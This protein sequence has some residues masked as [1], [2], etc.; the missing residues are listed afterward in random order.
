MRLLLTLALLISISSCAHNKIRKVRVNSRKIVNIDKTNTTNDIPNEN[1]AIEV[2]EEETH[3]I[4]SVEV[5][6]DFESSTSNNKEENKRN[7]SSD[8]ISPQTQS[9]S[10]LNEEEVAIA[11]KAEKYAK[12]S[13]RSFTLS[14]VLLLLAFPLMVFTLLPGWAYYNASRRSRYNTADGL[15]MENTAKIMGIVL[16]IAFVLAAT[17]LI[18]FILLL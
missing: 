8:D 1:L 2:V 14:I 15:K 5:T 3:E 17:V 12:K 4:E 18:L 9:S 10:D 7:I 11:I 13:L 16:T 6:N